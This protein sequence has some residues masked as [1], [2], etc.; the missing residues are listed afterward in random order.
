M[1]LIKI[2]VEITYNRI[3]LLFSAFLA[4]KLHFFVEF[5]INTS[6]IQHKS[7]TILIKLLIIMWNT[8]IISGTRL[9]L[10]VVKSPASLRNILLFTAHSQV[11]KHKKIYFNLLIFSDENSCDDKIDI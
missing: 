10:E 2:I 3:Y 1:S 7:G 9:I 4:V 8:F 11:V 5:G 6:S